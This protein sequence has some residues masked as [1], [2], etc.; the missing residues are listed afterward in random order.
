MARGC[1]C[2][3]PDKMYNVCLWLISKLHP[4][5]MLDLSR[6]ISVH[7]I[8][9]IC[10]WTSQSVQQL[11]LFSWLTFCPRA[12]KRMIRNSV[13]LITRCCDCLHGSQSSRKGSPCWS[14]CCLG[15]KATCGHFWAFF[16]NQTLVH[17]YCLFKAIKPVGLGLK[18][19]NQGFSRGSM[20]KQYLVGSVLESHW[21]GV[22]KLQYF[23]CW[24]EN[25]PTVWSIYRSYIGKQHLLA[26]WWIVLPNGISTS[27]TCLLFLF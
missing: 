20:T 15:S 3:I 17:L 13:W 11:W 22:I 18:L 6:W 14:G 9:A 10:Q 19:S 24:G 27:K 4:W 7:V 23:S 8:Q 25:Y 16:N 21:A 1:C 26:F 5:P 2:N 12:F